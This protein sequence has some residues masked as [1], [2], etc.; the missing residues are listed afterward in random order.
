MAKKIVIV[1][2][3]VAGVNAATK[4]VDNGY[5]GKDITIIDMGNDP[6]NRK[7]EEVM[8][9]FLGAGGWSDG[10]LT[11]HTAIGG[12]LSK[13]VGEEK[14][15]ALMDEVIN[16]FK[17]FH[18][19]PEEVQCSNPVE[20]PDFIKPYF[21][22]RLFP[23]WHVGTDYLH[24]IGKNWYDYLVSKNVNFIWN[25][26]VFKVDFESDLVYITINGKEGQYALDYDELIFGVGK[27]GIDFAQHIQDE[28]QLETEPKSVQIGVRFEAPQKHFQKLIDIS[29]DFKLYRKFEDKGVSLRSFCTNNNAAYVAVEKTYGDI[30]YNGHAKKD[31]KYLN[32]M[33]NFGILMEING[34]KDPFE[35]SR[36]VVKKCQVKGAYSKTTTGMYYSPNGTRNQSRTSEGESIR[37]IGDIYNNDN[38][39]NYNN[40]LGRFKDAFGEYAYYILDFIEDMKKVFPT[41]QDD[42]GIYIPEVKYLSPEPLVNYKDLGLSDYPNVHFV[43]DALSAR[44]ITVSGAQ[45]ILSVEKLIKDCEWDNIH[46][47]M[48]HFI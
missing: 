6:Y 34:I 47:D 41:L 33:T 38:G 44:G 17:R 43:G 36:N 48:I 1:G 42:W 32:G 24:E 45:G 35:W 2:A 14:A 3:G 37:A 10:K 39:E 12:Q 7:P 19:K 5:P 13:Y 30:T 40:I 16:N 20:E 18:P 26:R 22:L 21:G 11:Y 23:V 46:G 27:S 25:E 28:Y 8:T 31:P 4:L 9:G 15:M 29:Y